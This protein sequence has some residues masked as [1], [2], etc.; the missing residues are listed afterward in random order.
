MKIYKANF[1]YFLIVFFWA[2][3]LILAPLTLP[4]NSVKDLSGIVGREDNKE[5][6][7]K[8]N[9][10]AKFIY[11]TGDS[12]C[13]QLKRR[14]YFLNGNQLPFCSRCLGIFFGFAFAGAI[15]TFKRV[16]LTWQLIIIGLTPIGIDGTIQLFTSYESYNIIRLITGLLVGIITGFAVGQIIYEVSC[17]GKVKSSRADHTTNSAKNCD[18]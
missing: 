17:I 2:F 16:E 12:N 15:I 6:N 7:E 11:K 13:H 3:S 18:K 14:S 9:P 8:M 4:K 1:I 10:F 5:I